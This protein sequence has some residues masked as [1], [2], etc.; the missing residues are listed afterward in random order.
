VLIAEPFTPPGYEK[1]WLLEKV[2]LDILSG[3][4]LLKMPGPKVVRLSEKIQPLMTG[5]EFVL[6]IPPP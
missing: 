1:I 5:E 2:Q 4:A 6:K 3:E